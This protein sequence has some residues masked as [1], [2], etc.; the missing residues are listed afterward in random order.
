MKNE[1]WIQQELKELAARNLDRHLVTYTSD[2]GSVR[3]ED[4]TVINFSSN[5]YL[6]LSIHEEIISASEK[7]LLQAGTGAGASRLVTGT[8]DY[9]TDLEKRLAMI[10]LLL[11]SGADGNSRAQLLVSASSPARQGDALLHKA[12][13]QG[14][15]D[16]VE[17]LLKNDANADLR[18]ADGKTPAVLASENGHSKIA[19]LLQRRRSVATGTNGRAPAPSVPEPQNQEQPE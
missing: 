7:L 10:A 12:A 1:N 17:L 4:R 3:R 9:H 19:D 13:R 2:G 6:N 11:K 5:N 8:Y 14:W 16:V 18:D 15:T